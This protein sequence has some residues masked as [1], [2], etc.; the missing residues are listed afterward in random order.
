MSQDSKV[1][2]A[3]QCEGFGKYEFLAI[4]TGRCRLFSMS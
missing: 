2:E 3:R 4:R 1:A